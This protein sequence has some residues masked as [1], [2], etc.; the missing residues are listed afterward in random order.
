MTDRFYP[1]NGAELPSVTTV[2]SILDKPFLRFW[3][4]KYGT[5]RCQQMSKESQELGKLLHENIHD[6]FEKKLVGQT[7]DLIKIP[8]D[9][10]LKFVNKFEPQ[11]DSGETVLYGKGYAGTRDWKGTVLEEGR[12]KKVILDWKSS[13]SIDSPEYELQ[14]EAYYRCEEDNDVEEFWIVRLPKEGEIDFE[15]DIVKLKPCKIR[16]KVF[17]SLLFVFNWL[18]KRGK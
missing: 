5:G 7:P 6:Y 8:F 9:N 13:K 1:K 18:R 17:M 10:F 11:R 4:G 2:T 3:Y 16:F 14:L 12:R 15:R